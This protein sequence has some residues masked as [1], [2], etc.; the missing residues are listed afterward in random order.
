MKKQELLQNKGNQIRKD[1]L[2]KKIE[3]IKK[4]LVMQQIL[5]ND[6]KNEISNLKQ[7]NN[8]LKTS[9]EKLTKENKT[10]QKIK[11]EKMI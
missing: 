1:E 8:I 5:Y 10:L 2:I 11:E 6:M 9:I 3:K 7:E 4:Q